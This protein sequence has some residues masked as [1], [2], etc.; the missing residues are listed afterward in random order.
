MTPAQRFRPQ[1]QPSETGRP[2]II[3]DRLLCWHPLRWRGAVR[4]YSAQVKIDSSA[5]S[6][7]K[8]TVEMIE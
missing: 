6:S 2:A 5:E 7:R 8:V 3:P 1:M 4:P